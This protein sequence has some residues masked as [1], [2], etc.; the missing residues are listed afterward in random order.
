VISVQMIAAR[1][2]LSRTVRIP[3]A[4]GFARFVTASRRATRSRSKASHLFITPTTREHL[5]LSTLRE[6]TYMDHGAI[7]IGVSSR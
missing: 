6:F 1:G 5:A 2:R 4:G 7:C 3:D